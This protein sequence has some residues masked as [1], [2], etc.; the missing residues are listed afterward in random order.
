MKIEGNT[1][2]FKS[3]P[4]LFADERDGLKPNTVRL[5]DKHEAGEVN[6]KWGCI[7]KIQIINAAN[8]NEF[9]IKNILNITDITEAL[10]LPLKN[11]WRCFVFSWTH[12]ES[13]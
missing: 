5:L 2:F 10:S 1:I 6:D 11:G 13:A 4:D 3:F 9:I 8:L 12:E 7:E